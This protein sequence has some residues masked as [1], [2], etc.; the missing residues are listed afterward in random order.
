[1]FLAHISE[2]GL[3]EQSILEHL[4]E[5]ANLA[6]RFASA[7]GAEDW[8]YGCGLLHDIGKYSDSFQKRI[9]GGR[10]PITRLPVLKNCIK[11]K[12]MLAP[13]VYRGIIP[14]F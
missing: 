5:T 14:V 13:I 2:D 8:G 6:G 7:F 4:K 10:S 1:M 3:R 11:E 9:H 12:I